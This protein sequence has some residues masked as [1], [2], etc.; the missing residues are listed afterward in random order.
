[1]YSHNSLKCVAKKIKAEDVVKSR[2]HQVGGA[3]PPDNQ[4]KGIPRY[5][6]LTKLLRAPSSYIFLTN[7]ISLH[8]PFGNYVSGIFDMIIG[9]FSKKKNSNIE[10]NGLKLRIQRF[11]YVH[12]TYLIPDNI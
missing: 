3:V 1:M 9:I 5:E 10:D 11:P 2:T 7:L 4:V 6:Y 12:S 8:Y